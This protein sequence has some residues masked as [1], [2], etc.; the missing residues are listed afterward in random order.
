MDDYFAADLFRSHGNRGSTYLFLRW[1]A[2]RFGPDL[3][4]A[5]I[6]SR[7][8][9]ATNLE[10]C[11]GSPFASL[12]RAWTLDLFQNG[13]E[14]GANQRAANYRLS[15]EKVR[16]PLPEWELAGPRATHVSTGTVDRWTALGTTSHYAIVDGSK[17][18]AIEIE[19]TGPPEAEL[20]VTALLLG[21]DHPRLIDPRSRS[22]AEGEYS[23]APHQ[24]TERRGGSTFAGFLGTAR[25]GREPTRLR[26]LSR[27]SG[28]RGAEKTL[29]SLDVPASGELTSE[30]ILLTGLSAVEGPLVVK[31]VGTDAQGRRVSAW[32]DV[33][34]EGQDH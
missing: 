34:I 12:F 30:P 6:H 23:S 8:R 19:V 15:R 2:L 18:G 17:S 1:C 31:V 13:L 21:D 9:G 4:P 3:I 14:P 29:G 28:G 32:A 25:A 33:N 24:R 20:Q 10:G 22:A 11:T 7:L 16:S 26:V 5:L 27:P